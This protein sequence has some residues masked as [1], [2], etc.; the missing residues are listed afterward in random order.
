M[1]MPGESDAP[2]P[3]PDDSAVA[4]TF[5]RHEGPD[6]RG[7][8]AAEQSVDT[9]APAELPDVRETPKADATPEPTGPPRDE[10][11]RFAKT[12]E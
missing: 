8:A 11:G 9:S 3:L 5:A 4:D 10:Q 12:I 2:M 6:P 1:S 7:E